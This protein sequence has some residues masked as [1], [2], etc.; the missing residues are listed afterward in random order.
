MRFPDL[1]KA[2]L[3]AV[4]DPIAFS[5]ATVPVITLDGVYRNTQQL[6]R[7][8]N[9]TLRVMD[10]DV[11]IVPYSALVKKGDDVNTGVSIHKVAGNPIRDGSGGMIVKLGSENITKSAKAS[12][13]DR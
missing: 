6:A 7:S 9:K 5:R 4:G 3:K 1:A 10:C 13:L 8:K 11:V 2:T 12:L